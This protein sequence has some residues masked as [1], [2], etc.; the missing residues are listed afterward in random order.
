MSRQFRHKYVQSKAGKLMFHFI[1]II[2]GQLVDKQYLSY[3][4]P[5]LRTHFRYTYY[6]LLLFDR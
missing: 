2:A 6:V 4:V 3:I 1:R 5:G